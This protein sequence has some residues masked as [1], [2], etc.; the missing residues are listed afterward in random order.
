MKATSVRSQVLK[1]MSVISRVNARGA[2][3]PL[4]SSEQSEDTA[5]FMV[6]DLKKYSQKMGRWR[7][8]TLRVLGRP[9]FWSVVAISHRSRLPLKHLHCFC[10]KTF[11]GEEGGHIRRLVTYRCAKFEL[12]YTQ[13]LQDGTM[14]FQTRLAFVPEH[15]QWLNRLSI[16][17]IALYYTS[18][19]RRVVYQKRRRSCLVCL[20]SVGS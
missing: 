2:P 3:P 19:M 20:S 1:A 12:E 7:G 11:D 17:L 15:A 16:A 6:D 9:E 18:M 5:A 8:D 4:L 10:Q 13:M 14:F